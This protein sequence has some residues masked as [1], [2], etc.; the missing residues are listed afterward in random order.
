MNLR[1]TCPECGSHYF[2]STVDGTLV[3]SCHGTI[4]TLE[5]GSRHCG[6]SWPEADDHLYGLADAPPP[7]GVQEAPVQ[8]HPDWHGGFDEDGARCPHCGE[9]L[10]GPYHYADGLRNDGDTANMQ[11]N[12]GR[13]YRVT[14]CISTSFATDPIEAPS[15]IAR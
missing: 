10:E 15:E 3:R 5:G 7:S 12:C 1:F 14:M 8:T 13:W 6:F 4:G 2:G 11:C 9:I